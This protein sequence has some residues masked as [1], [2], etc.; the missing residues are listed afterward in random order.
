MVANPGYQG[1]IT[2]TAVIS[3]PD[4]LSEIERQVVAYVTDKLVL[5]ITKSAS[6]DPVDKGAELRYTIQVEALGLQATALVI[7]DTIPEGTTYV[8]GSATSGGQLVGD[9]VRWQIGKLEPNE[10]STFEFR[11]T[12]ND[13]SQ[14]TNDQYAVT[15]AE[16]VVGVGDRVVTRISGGGG[17]GGDVYLPIILKNY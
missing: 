7:T 12:V 8:P 9:Q 4:L 14:V 16:G 6:P 17:V 11:V 13:G 10:S 1:P 5:S 3:H 2:N 15:S